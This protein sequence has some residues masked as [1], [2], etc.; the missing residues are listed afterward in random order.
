MTITV[1][2]RNERTHRRSILWY[3]ALVHRIS[4]LLLVCFLP[5][6]FLALGLALESEAQLEGFL[7]WTDSSAVKL[8]EMGLVFLLTVH[9]IGGVRVLALENLS[10]RND[11]KNLA[12]LAIAA[13]AI[14][15]ALF[16]LRVI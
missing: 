7:R 5:L 11:H 15:A 12:G 8:S 14:V 13:A 1:E 3:A 6:H 16:F 10:W 2:N 4:G 9:L